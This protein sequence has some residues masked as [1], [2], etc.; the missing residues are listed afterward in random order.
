MSISNVTGPVAGVGTF[1]VLLSN[2]AAPGGASFDVAGFSFELAVSSAS[3]VQFTAADTATITAAYLFDGVGGAAVDPAFTLSLDP[4]PNTSFAGSDIAFLVPSIMLNPGD[5]FGLGLISYSV[6]PNAPPGD[7]QISFIPAGTSLSDAVGVMVDFETDS[8]QGIIRV[9]GAVVPEPTT[10]ALA[11]TAI[12][13]T[14]ITSARKPRPREIDARSLIRSFRESRWPH[15]ECGA[16]S[17]EVAS[18]SARTGGG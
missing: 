12:S 18:S 9:A 6:A 1:E 4:F 3:G 17:F 5:V 7:V 2:T 15:P 14:T 10:L 8:S 11:I 16:H 13:L